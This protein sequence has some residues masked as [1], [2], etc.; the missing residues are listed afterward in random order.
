[1]LSFYIFLRLIVYVVGDKPKPHYLRY[2]AYRCKGL[3]VDGVDDTFYRRDLSAVYN[4]NEHRT[5]FARV[6]TYCRK[7]GYTAL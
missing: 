3:R 4:A 7:G 6:H 5:F 1:M 2:G